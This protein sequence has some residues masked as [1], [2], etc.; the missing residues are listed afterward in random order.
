MRFGGYWFLKSKLTV[1]TL[2]K[3]ALAYRSL[4]VLTY[5]AMDGVEA[6]T[7]LEELV[8]SPDIALIAVDEVLLNDI[9][10]S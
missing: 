8:V 1:V 2:P 9:D 3:I 7:Y 6:L 4:G 5:A 10:E